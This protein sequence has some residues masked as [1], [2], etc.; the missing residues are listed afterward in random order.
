MLYNR[1]VDI[2][3]YGGPLLWLIACF[4]LWLYAGG[5]GALPVRYWPDTGIAAVALGARLVPAFTLDRGL[6]F[7]ITAHWRSGLAVLG[8]SNLYADL[9]M[10]YR[11][12]YP[13][14]HMYLSALLV[15]L[16]GEMASSFLVADKV[17]PSI[18]G[19]GVGRPAIPPIGRTTVPDQTCRFATLAT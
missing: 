9:N 16:S 5:A 17:A 4:A 12:P 1:Q 6:T 7:D 8:G 3:A 10:L 13:P 18:A 15:W 2:P 19:A 14:L 11:Y